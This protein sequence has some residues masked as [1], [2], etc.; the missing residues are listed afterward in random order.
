MTANIEISS[1]MFDR[2]MHE[3]VGS[4]DLNDDGLV[5]K[6]SLTGTYETI[7]TSRTFVGSCG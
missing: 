3:S 4:V 1:E 7:L 2:L 5:D 6:S